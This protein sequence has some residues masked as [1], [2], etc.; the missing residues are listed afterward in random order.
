MEDREVRTDE[1]K[2]ARN[3]EPKR[4]PSKKRSPIQQNRNES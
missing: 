3:M 4:F 1:D 2:D